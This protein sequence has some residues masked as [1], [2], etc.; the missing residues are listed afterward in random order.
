MNGSAGLMSLRSPFVRPAFRR[1]LAFPLMLAV[2]LFAGCSRVSGPTPSEAPSPSV[3]AAPTAVLA[4]GVLRLWMAPLDRL[5]PIRSR[6][7]GFL[8]LTSLLYDSL[9]TLDQNDEPVP[10]LCTSSYY[11][12][13]DDTEWTF[14][15]VSGAVFNDGTTLLPV[16]AAASANLWLQQGTGAAH[17]ALAALSPQFLVEGTTSLVV[18]LATPGPDLPRLLRFPIIPASCAILKTPDPSV[19]VPGSGLFRIVSYEPG[20]GLRLERNVPIAGKIQSIFVSEYKDEATALEDFHSDLLDAI[21]LDETA[22]RNLRFRKSLKIGRY[23]GED[24]VIPVFGTTKGRML[25]EPAHLAEMSRILKALFESDEFLADFSVFPSSR[26]LSTGLASLVYGDP[27]GAPT[28]PPSPAADAS[29][30]TTATP[31]PSSIPEPT[32]TPAPVVWTGT[33][34]VVAVTGSF[35]AEIGASIVARLRSLGIPAS[36]R[37]LSDA[38]FLVS[39]ANGWY[40]IAIRSRTMPAVPGAPATAQFSARTGTPF[41]DPL[42]RA[43][44]LLLGPRVFGEPIPC[45]DDIYRGIEDAWVWSGS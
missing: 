45:T 16:D 4:S 2:A 37:T 17:D 23:D 32:P 10:L 42:I 41:P 43:R 29:A 26:G 36:L 15:M 38:N 18:R 19:P 25:S 34:D 12:N 20:K 39:V 1:L 22:Y 27:T 35:E 28:A 31:S 5:D 40:D 11:A 8:A 9:F 44:G 24:L 6:D 30:S 3:S 21:P 14:P 7:E 13:Q 33:V